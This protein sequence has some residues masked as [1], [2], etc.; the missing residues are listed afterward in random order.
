MN[1]RVRLPRPIRAYTD[2]ER[3]EAVALSV[4]IGPARA[5]V[6]LNMSRQTLKQWRTAAGVTPLPTPAQLKRGK[7]PV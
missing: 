7:S 5:A 6:R 3:R 4:E 1:K 2:E